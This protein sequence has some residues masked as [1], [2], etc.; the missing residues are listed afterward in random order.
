LCVHSSWGGQRKFGRRLMVKTVCKGATAHWL[1][2]FVPNS[3]SA[4]ISC[5]VHDCQILTATRTSKHSLRTS[6]CLHSNYISTMSNRHCLLVQIVE[7]AVN[8]QVLISP[9]SFPIKIR[10]FSA[11]YIRSM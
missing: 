8:Q 9:P 5:L 11:Y 2:Q 1:L 6:V 7:A 10:C 4:R 3:R